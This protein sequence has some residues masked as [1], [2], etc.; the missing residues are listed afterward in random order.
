[1]IY[2]HDI[3]KR[4]NIIIYQ[5]FV[6]VLLGPFLVCWACGLICILVIRFRGHIS[7]SIVL[8]VGECSH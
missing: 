8:P 5:I 1:M 7:V 4:R 2:E 6:T 3:W